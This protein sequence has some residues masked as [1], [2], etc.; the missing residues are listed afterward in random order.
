MNFFFYLENWIVCVPRN[1]IVDEQTLE[2]PTFLLAHILI[3][4][5][6]L[7]E[8]HFTN[9]LGT[10]IKLDAKKLIA[11]SVESLV[12]FE[13]LFYTKGLMK[14]KVWCIESPLIETE[15]SSMPPTGLFVVR[16]L[17]DAIE[18][19]WKETNSKVIFRK[20]DN[21]CKQFI[22][23]Q[24]N[25]KMKTIEL[26]KIRHSTEMVYNHCLQNMLFN[27]RLKEK[28]RLDSN[29]YKILKIA[30]ETYIMS[31]LYE[32]VF[33]AIAVS[34]IEHG[35]HFNKVIRNLSDVQLPYFNVDQKYMDVV[36][37]VRVELLKIEESTTAI[38]KLGKF[39]S[40]FFLHVS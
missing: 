3:P 40:A 6:E 37:C 10:E 38:E 8:S 20:I 13:E 28:C 23:S 15:K 4:N 32:F 22:R 27:K 2:N 31:V 16:D 7:P 14:Y 5:D 24:R 26:D 21:V 19:I 12:L 29:F 39:F 11:A 35:E 25:S 17:K 33:D 9:L 30:L 1:A 18:L 36:A 34:T